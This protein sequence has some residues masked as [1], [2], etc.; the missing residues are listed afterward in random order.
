MARLVPRP[1]APPTQE[2]TDFT[3]SIQQNLEE[4]FQIAH[5][6][7]VKTAA[8]AATDGSIGDVTPVFD[9]V[10]Y[11]LYVKFPTGWRSVVLA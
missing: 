11:K 4:A 7:R 8:P 6:H 2:L 10:N 5:D 3:V 9:G 1:L